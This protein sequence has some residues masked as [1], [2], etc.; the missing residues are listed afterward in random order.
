MIVLH[1]H[2]A[3]GASCN[4]IITWNPLKSNKTCQTLA[5]IFEACSFVNERFTMQPFWL[6]FFAGSLCRL[7]AH[8]I[9]SDPFWRL[10]MSVSSHSVWRIYRNSH[11][12]ISDFS[13]NDRSCNPWKLVTKQSLV[14]SKKATAFERTALPLK[15]THLDILTFQLHPSK[16]PSFF[17]SHSTTPTPT[18]TKPSK[19]SKNKN[20]AKKGAKSPRRHLV[21]LVNVQLNVK[22]NVAKEGAKSQCRHRCLVNLKLSTQRPHVTL[23]SFHFC[24]GWDLE[25]WS[26]VLYFR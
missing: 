18:P 1:G 19:P 2:G 4:M 10:F 5:R 12:D 15:E 7:P 25:S 26:S 8:M 22:K 9:L 6:L 24:D 3:T 13:E 20:V 21:V 11:K 16:I 17:I 23:S 14:N